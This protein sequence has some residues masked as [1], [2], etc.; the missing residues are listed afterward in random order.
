MHGL[1]PTDKM[2]AIALAVLTLVGAV[3]G[4]SSG[5]PQAVALNA[6]DWYGLLG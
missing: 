5:P 1:R 4:S 2:I 3:V 6:K